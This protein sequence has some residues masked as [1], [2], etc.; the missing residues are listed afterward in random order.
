[1]VTATKRVLLGALLWFCICGLP[2]VPSAKHELTCGF[3]FSSYV[4]LRK[5]RYSPLCAACVLGGNFEPARHGQFMIQCYWSSIALWPLTVQGQC[6][7]DST[8]YPAYSTIL[9]EVLPSGIM[10]FFNKQV[11]KQRKEHTQFHC[12]LEVSSS[13]WMLTL[14]MSKPSTLGTK[15]R[16]CFIFTCTGFVNSRLARDGPVW[17]LLLLGGRWI[18]HWCSSRVTGCSSSSEAPPL[19]IL[20]LVQFVSRGTRKPLVCPGKPI[21]SLVY[22]DWS[23]DNRTQLWMLS[24]SPI[25]LPWR[26]WYWGGIW[27]SAAEY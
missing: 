27:K 3:K 23:T 26:N 6:C 13:F 9:A 5:V 14:P 2:V 8:T 19:S 20:L 12:M 4:L 10:L 7:Q 1:M 21:A 18:P 24:F 11:D 22:S 15:H 16:C 17:A 25:R